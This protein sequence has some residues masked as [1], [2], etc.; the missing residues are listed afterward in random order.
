MKTILISLFML[1]ILRIG[2]AQEVVTT[3]GDVSQG[4]GYSLSWTLGECVSETVSGGGYIL[5]QG[6]QQ[7]EITVTS[8]QQPEGTSQI[9]VY[10]NPVDQFLSIEGSTGM[11][12]IQLFDA[13]GKL[14]VYEKSTSNL[15]NIS[16]ANLG[17]GVYKLVVRTD[18]G[19]RYSFSII[20]N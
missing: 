11:E 18:E 3:A 9:L 8:I 12:L 5:T 10:P 13:T 16:F 15:V 2:A 6:F 1:L 17:A 20:K 19:Q 7:P 14:V 4:G